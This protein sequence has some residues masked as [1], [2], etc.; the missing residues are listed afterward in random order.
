VLQGTTDADQHQ[1]AARCILVVDDSPAVLKLMGALFEEQ[2][3]KVCLASSAQAAKQYLQQHRPPFDLVLSDIQMPG[4]TGFDLLQWIKQEGSPYQDLPVLLT[5]AQL[6]EAENRLKGLSMGAVD[7]VVRPLDLRELVLR[8]IN[9]IDHCQHIK[10]LETS[11]QSSENLAMLGRLMTASNHEVKN[12]ATIVKVCADQVQRLL[13][14]ALGQDA[15]PA[16]RALASLAEASTL[17]TDVARNLGGFATVRSISRP[18]ELS[19]VA[20]QIIALML[21]MV[22]P[23]RLELIP[24]T[25]VWVMAHEVRL[26][27]VLINLVL[28]A[29]DAIAELNPAQGGKIMI[30]LNATADQGCLCVTDNGI[31]LDTPGERRDFI[32]FS[33]TK[34]LRGGHGLG[35]WLCSRLITDMNGTLAL[36][37]GGVAT[38]VTAT[39]RFMRCEPPPIDS[40]AQDIASY[41]ESKDS[42]LA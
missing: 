23:Y 6:P 14:D 42:L 2:G 40:L 36:A 15:A 37:S 1:R 28:N 29:H 20:A 18:L 5:T 19:S 10:A 39:L 41:L 7:Y 38:G 3:I 12:L 8:T 31:G 22:K 27:Q 17:L 4:E 16:K 35:L 24:H 21:P 11:L 33:T 13:G 34:K 32:A 9:A 25:P 30:N 26:K